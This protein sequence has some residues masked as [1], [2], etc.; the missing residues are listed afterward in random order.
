MKPSLIPKTSLAAKSIYRPRKTSF[1]AVF[2]VGVFFLSVGLLAGGYFYKGFLEGRIKELNDTLKRTEA[3][4]EPASIEELA[5]TSELIK[6][7][8]VILAEHKI[9]SKV[10]LLLENLTLPSVRFSSFSF[11]EKDGQYSVLMNGEAK[12]YTAIA[13]Q[14]AVFSKSA[15]VEKASFSN[16]ALKSEGNVS[17]N[18]SLIINPEVLKL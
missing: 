3:E 9:P 6:N 15:L 11:G 10:F 5:R 4:F 8:K 16:F 17:F 1:L 12:S 18:V 2:S 14:A 13:E 7:S